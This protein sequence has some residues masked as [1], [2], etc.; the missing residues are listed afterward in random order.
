M[1]QG[2]DKPIIIGK[3]STGDRYIELALSGGEGETG[4]SGSGAS[5]SSRQSS[6][7]GASGRIYLTGDKADAAR[8]E[9][10]LNYINY[11]GKKVNDLGTLI[12]IIDNAPKL[13]FD[14]RWANLRSGQSLVGPNG[15]TYIKK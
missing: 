15:K 13:D 8:A 1:A 2:M 5:E 11:G 7:G 14:S 12:Q 10:Y 6:K 9:Q 4:K 3:T